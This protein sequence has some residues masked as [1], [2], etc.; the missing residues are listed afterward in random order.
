MQMNL[1]ISL[2]KLLVIWMCFI[3]LVPSYHAEGPV[4]VSAEEA[5]EET[6]PSVEL[7]PDEESEESETTVEPE[8]ESTV[9]SKMKPQ[10]NQKMNP[11]SNQKMK[12]L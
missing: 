2:R 3:I 5:E 8:N 1:K 9:E 4:L 12:P 7:V 11:Q 6:V 10:S